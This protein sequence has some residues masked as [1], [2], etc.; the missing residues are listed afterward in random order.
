M[1]LRL[2]AGISLALGLQGTEVPA[3]T[4]VLLRAEQTVSSRTARVG[5]RIHLQTAAPVSDGKQIVVP[6]GT[7]IDA[8]V[9]AVK[10]SGRIK[11]EAELELRAKSLMFADGRVRRVPSM[12]V[13]SPV[14]AKVRRDHDRALGWGIA[15]LAMF[16]VYSIE[17]GP[18]PDF[19]VFGAPGAALVSSVVLRRGGEAEIRMGTLLDGHFDQSVPL[20]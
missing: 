1:L 16:T 15:L 2:I 8:E 4:H 7:Y 5:D 3:G 20:D 11:G 14:P 10:R 13:E 12:R 19:V 18:Q 9:I 6:A 17:Y